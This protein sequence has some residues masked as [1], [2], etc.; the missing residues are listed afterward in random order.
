[1]A[2]RLM[3]YI[4]LLYQDLLKQ[5]ELTAEGLLPLV[6][7]LVLYNEEMAWWAPEELADLIDQKH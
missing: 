7:P 6:I 3:A 4:A 1:M 2:V 5:G